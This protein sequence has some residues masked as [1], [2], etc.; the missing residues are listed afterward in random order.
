MRNKEEIVEEMKWRNLRITKQRLVLLE[1]ICAGHY[2][3]GKEIY[4]EAIKRDPR[5]GL[6][7]VYRMLETLEEIGVIS[8]S[9]RLTDRGNG[10]S[11][12]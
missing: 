12:C 11:A 5:I 2:E 10:R 8:R 3:S 7:T 9:Y 6:A 4:Y 1:V